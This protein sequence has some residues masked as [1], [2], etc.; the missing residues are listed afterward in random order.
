ML[1]IKLNPVLR[2]LNIIRDRFIHNNDHI[3]P[4][5]TDNIDNYDSDYEPRTDKKQRMFLQL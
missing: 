1:S 4:N 2:S 5:I 3:E